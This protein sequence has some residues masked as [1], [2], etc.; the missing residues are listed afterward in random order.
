MFSKKIIPIDYNKKK[1]VII[2]KRWTSA[3]VFDRSHCPKYNVS[4]IFVKRHIPFLRNTTVRRL[5]LSWTSRLNWRA[6]STQRGTENK[7]TACASVRDIARIIFCKYNARRNKSA[8]ARQ[9]IH[10][11]RDIS[12]HR[13]AGADIS[14]YDISPFFFFFSPFFPFNLPSAYAI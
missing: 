1:C 4:R 8:F 11:V 13:A 12:P 5:T 9:R 2:S 10:N 14:R 6:G 7:R 3:G